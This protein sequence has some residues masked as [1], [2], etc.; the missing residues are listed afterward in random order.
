MVGDGGG[1]IDWAGNWSAAAVAVA[2]A[3]VV[4]VVVV[5][6]AN[7]A[8]AANSTATL[9]YTRESYYP[10]EQGEIMN[11]RY[12]VISK[13]GYGSSSTVWLAR[14]FVESTY[15][16]LKVFTLNQRTGNEVSVYNHIQSTGTDHPG[17]KDIRKLLDHFFLQGPNGRRACLVHE[18]FGMSVLELDT[19]GHN[20]GVIDPAPRLDQ[21]KPLIRRVLYALD[22]LHRAAEVIHTGNV[23]TSLTPMRN[24]L[25]PAASQARMSRYE[26]NMIKNPPSRKILQD[27]TIYATR[28]FPTEDGLPVLCE[29]G[30]ARFG[31]KHN[32]GMI[33]PDLHRIPG[34]ILVFPSW[35]YKVDSWGVGMLAWDC[36]STRPLISNHRRDDHWDDGAHVAELVALLGHPPREFTRRGTHGHIFWDENGSWTDLVTIPDRSL[37]QAAADIEGED[38]EDFLPWLRRALQW[39]P[40][41]RPTI[42]DLFMDP[43]LMKGMRARRDDQALK[44]YPD[45]VEVVE[46]ID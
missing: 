22:Y 19:I 21:A 5:N 14:D 6:A 13:I 27:R 41:D 20:L 17:Q 39:D 44:D 11:G 37:E 25:F 36:I 46:I 8:N 7:A 38:P 24:L 15:V 26:E 31:D 2:V 32:C 16:A 42:W 29:F 9:S 40:K 28:L 35:D 33:M 10:V 34:V 23:S 1:L 45:I 12:Q 3:V 18:L 43:W 30:E 4:V